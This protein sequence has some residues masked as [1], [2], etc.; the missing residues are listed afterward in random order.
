MA[1]YLHLYRRL[2]PGAA[3]ENKQPA[4][5]ALV[6]ATLEAAIQKYCAAAL[7]ARVANSREIDPET[8]LNG[9]LWSD[10]DL[11][12]TFAE[13]T[14]HPQLVLTKFGEPEILEFYGVEKLS[15]EVWQSMATLRALGKGAPLRVMASVDCFAYDRSDELDDLLRIYD[16]RDHRCDASGTGTVFHRS[17]GDKANGM[18]FLPFI[19]ARHISWSDLRP[20]FL[21]LGMDVSCAPSAAVDYP[22]FFWAPFALLKYYEAH[23]PFA[24]AFLQK[25]ACDLES[26][27][28]VIAG[29]CT[30]AF[31]DWRGQP[32]T[33][34][35][36]WQRAYLGPSARESFVEHIRD[37]LEAGLVAV[38][39]SIR[40]CEVDVEGAFDFLALV[41]SRRAEI[42]IGVPGPHS[43]FLSCGDASYFMD[44]SWIYYRL[45]RLFDDL[46]LEN[47]NFKGEA[48]EEYVRAGR[49]ELPIKKCDSIDGTSKQARPV[50]LTKIN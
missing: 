23:K 41:D 7:C 13:I 6:R 28:A 20:W 32:A 14:E 30:S 31:R 12:R 25:Y 36:Y 26:L 4:T 49:S 43:V 18:I 9:A 10:P 8:I 24:S 37:N 11:R 16:D 38:P 19:N 34:Y 15:F 5:I 42:D 48:L 29:I 17:P 27:V 2:A 45:M 1:Y 22:N 47:Q 3:G 33:T 39:L 46:E 35:R 21:H 40:A 44:Y 50:P